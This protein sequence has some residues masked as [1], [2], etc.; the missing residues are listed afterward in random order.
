MN[1]S[2]LAGGPSRWKAFDSDA[3]VAD[4]DALCAEIVISRHPRRASPLPLDR[5]LYKWRHRFESFFCTLEEF[6]RIAMRRLQDGSQLH[7]H[8][9]SRRCGYQATDES[10]HASER[11][12]PARQAMPGSRRS[13]L[14]DGGRES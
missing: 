7:R 6:R 13:Q 2:Q 10:P 14:S 4:L 5:D 3:I 11:G 1:E 12:T 9:P 8:D